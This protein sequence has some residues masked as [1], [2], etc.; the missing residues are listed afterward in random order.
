MF[1]DGSIAYLICPRSSD[2]GRRS[3]LLASIFAFTGLCAQQWFVTK[4]RKEDIQ[5]ILIM[6][7]P[8]PTWFTTLSSPRSRPDFFS[9]KISR[10]VSSITSVII[11]MVCTKGF[12]K[13]SIALLRSSGVPILTIQGRNWR[14]KKSLKFVGLVRLWCSNWFGYFM[15][16][17]LIHT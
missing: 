12:G 17:E 8:R 5:R 9:K 2:S 13:R 6:S 14:S 3:S 15:D 7:F 4:I 1:D 16:R 11:R 10:E